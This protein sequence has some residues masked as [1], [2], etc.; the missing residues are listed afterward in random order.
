MKIR[1]IYIVLR[2]VSLPR[3]SIVHGGQGQNI[4]SITTAT[5]HR[6]QCPLSS[7]S[8]GDNNMPV[9]QYCR[10]CRQWSYWAVGSKSPPPNKRTANALQEDNHSPTYYFPN[11]CLCAYIDVPV[12][13]YMTVHV[14]DP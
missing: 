11:A 13:V 14:K 6:T 4:R 9:G 10:H 8:K 7:S 3:L 1:A 2:K 5:E 12:N